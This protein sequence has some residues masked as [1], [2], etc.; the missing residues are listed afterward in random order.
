MLQLVQA[1]R[2]ENFDKSN[3]RHLLID[4]A[5]EAD[6]LA[7][8]LHWHVFLE[9]DNDE[10]GTM[11]SMFEELYTELMERLADESH[12]THV[13]IIK[14]IK[15]R[16]KLYSL[17]EFIKSNKKEKHVQKKETLRKVVAKG[18]S[19]DMEHLR[20]PEPIPLDPL[21]YAKGVEPSK[22][23]VFKSAMWP[24]LM[25]F[26]AQTDDPALASKAIKNNIY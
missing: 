5:M 6:A 3:L 19:F 9:K 8:S 25:S 2:Y 22:C 18:G 1:Y 23:S 11:K 26:Y 4:K 12:A 17:A 15:L 13:N 20:D 24:L 10:N 7:N 14:Q 16:D 21:I